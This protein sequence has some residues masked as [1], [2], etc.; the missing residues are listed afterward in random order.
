ML[1]TSWTGNFP[2]A[3]HACAIPLGLVG[4][5]RAWAETDRATLRDIGEAFKTQRLY[6][7]RGHGAFQALPKSRK[8]KGK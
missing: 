8:A 1:V 5:A 4:A 2:V 7:Q 6:R 3:Q